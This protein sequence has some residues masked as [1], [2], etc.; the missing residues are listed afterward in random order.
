MGTHRVS[1]T[2]VSYREILKARLN[3]EGYR[4]LMRI[5]NPALHEFIAKYIELCNP[6][7]VYVSKG[8]HE[9]VEY[10]RD[11]A[12][13]NG[14]ETKLAMKGHTVHFD[15]YYD[16]ARDREHT[17]ILVSKGVELGS[18]LRTGDREERLKEIHE[19]LR[20]IMKGHELY[21]CFYSLGP[22]GSE[23][24]I[25]CIQLTD[26]SYVA[27]S[28]NI[29]YRHGYDEFVRQGSHVR[30]FKFVHSEGELDEN[31]T[32]KNLDKRRIY[33]DIEG[34]TVYSVNTQYGGN[35][36]GLKKLAMRLAINR[37]SEEGW[38]TEH[39]LVMGIHGPNGR[40]TYFTGAFPSMCGK[41][42]TSMMD[43]ETIVGDDIVYLRKRDG[44]VHAVNVEK[45]IFGIIHGI[46]SKDDP[47][48]WEVLHSPVEIIFSNVL[49]T[50][51]GRV[52]WVGKD[53]KVPPRG[54][55]HSG[56][57][58]IGKKD[59]KGKEIPC[60]HLNAR[61]TVELKYFKNLD[62]KLDD[63]NGVMVGAIVYGGRDSNTWMPVQESFSWEH[64]IIT[65]GAALESETTAATLG[66]EGVREFNPM[67]NLDFLSILIGRYVQDN[68]NFGK[69]L[70]KPPTI[71]AVNYFL[72]DEHGNFLNEKIDKRVWFKWMELRVHKDVDAIDTPTGRM[73]KYDDLK[74]LFK[75]TL[76]KDYPEEAY[77]RQF[78]IRIPENLSKLDRVTKIYNDMTEVP[79][80]V[81]E[82]FEEQRQRL[83]KAREKYGDYISPF[84]LAH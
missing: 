4:R 47:I 53:G 11:I 16:L 7:N 51:D 3:E 22:A 17:L 8:S 9:D 64:G 10:I 39:M 61:F 43:G 68:L 41:T 38:L 31:R 32:S 79:E 21:V 54:Y 50:E 58:W 62:P 18:R 73:P 44:A 66:K 56:K 55:N 77:I 26:S 69:G 49:V 23:F 1:D 30:P 46:N 42:S 34:D 83:N 28:E 29:L 15:N 80:R 57:W 67:S 48:Q 37:A 71:F 27:H 52:H 24:S 20:N 36:I 84:E 2:A 78:T 45:G 63:P 35:T 70:T 72:A 19:L 12:I 60:S 82:V 81:F 25:P 40:T 74:M 76:H 14:E 65:M 59:A 13:R 33:I 5:D 6:D 75:Q